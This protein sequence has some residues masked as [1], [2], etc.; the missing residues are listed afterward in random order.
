M[1]GYYQRPDLNSEAFTPDG[2]FRTGDLGFIDKYN[3]LS[4]RGRVK[5]MILGPGG[6]NIY[7]E[8]IETLINNQDFVQ[9]SLVVPENGGLV[10]L[11]KL[12]VDL[13]AEKMSLSIKE[14]REEAQKYIKKIRNDVNSE[15]SAFSKISDVQLQEEPFDRTPT[16]KIKRF[17][18]PK[19]KAKAEERK[20][21][22]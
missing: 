14:A 22:K 6:E 13:M 10:A 5:T 19:K 1:K 18:Y 7:P 11:I 8:M 2:Y 4:I 12:D 9:E 16:Q 17:L 15:L 3:R 20:D 21:D